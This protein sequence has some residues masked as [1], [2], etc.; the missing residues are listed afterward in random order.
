MVRLGRMRQEDLQFGDQ[1]RLHSEFEDSLGQILFQKTTKENPLCLLVQW[2][3]ILNMYAEEFN[4][5]QHVLTQP[6][7]QKKA[8]KGSTWNLLSVSISPPQDSSSHTDS[9]GTLPKSTW[10]EQGT[11]ETKES[12]WLLEGGSRETGFLVL[13]TFLI[14]FISGW[15]SKQLYVLFFK[16]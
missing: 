7:T 11:K 10:V 12:S 13:Y 16:F 5:C 14:L 2:P 9:Y 3:E 8:H 4:L 15:M 1:G 6:L